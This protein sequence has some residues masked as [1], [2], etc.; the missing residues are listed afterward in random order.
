MKTI[1]FIENPFFMYN[2][3][4]CQGEVLSVE[5]FPDENLT[6][7]FMDM[8]GVGNFTLSNKQVFETEKQLKA[9]LL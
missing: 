4:V 7:Y 5:Y 9:S 8:K 1:Q 2:D 3:R 6:V